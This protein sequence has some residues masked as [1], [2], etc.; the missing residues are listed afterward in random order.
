MKRRRLNQVLVFV[1]LCLAIFSFS[2]FVISNV[3]DKTYGSERFASDMK[4]K[5]YKF[6]LKDVQEDFLPTVRRRLII[7]N[8]NEAIDIYLYNNSNDMEADSKRIDNGGCSYVNGNKSKKVSW[9]SIPHFYK[10]GNIIIQYIGINE[11][12][13]SDLKDI[14]GEQFAGFR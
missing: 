11:K 6:E 3:K 1:I 8:K 14:C 10:K 7:N 2:S 4:S 9:S 13:I 12:I 5:N